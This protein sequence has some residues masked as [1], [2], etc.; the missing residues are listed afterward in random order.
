MKRWTIIVIASEALSSVT[1]PS[2]ASAHYAGPMGLRSDPFAAV[3]F[4]LAPPCCSQPLCGASAA[5]LTRHPSRN[6]RHTLQQVSLARI[7]IVWGK[8]MHG[9]QLHLMRQINAASAT[10]QAGGGDPRR[11]KVADRHNCICGP[12]RNDVVL[13]WAI[14]VEL[15][16]LAARRAFI[17]E[18]VLGFDAFNGCCPG[19]PPKRA[20]EICGLEL[21]DIRTWRR[22]KEASPAVMPGQR[23]RAQSERRLRTARHRRSPALG[24][25]IRVAGRWPCRGAVCLSEDAG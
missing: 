7:I 12:S 9:L 8:I 22:Y 10:A 25:Q 20:A 11:V 15:E 21:N 23:T 24:R 1:G 4:T 17:N 16:R 6:P 19:Y 14:A 5:S 3:F 18:H 2:R 13:A